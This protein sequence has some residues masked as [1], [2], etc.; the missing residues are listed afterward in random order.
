MSPSPPPYE[1]S[2]W[3][4]TVATSSK[5][6]NNRPV[7]VGRFAKVLFNWL[8]KIQPLR[9]IVPAM[10]SGGMDGRRLWQAGNGCEG[11]ASGAGRAPGSTGRIT[12]A[13]NGDGRQGCALLGDRRRR[14]LCRPCRHGD[15][16]RNVCRQDPACADKG[17]MD[18]R[19]HRQDHASARPSRKR[20]IRSSV[21]P[22]PPTARSWP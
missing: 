15:L 20:P 12:E 10:R 2:C 5:K 16:R 22:R 4:A 11:G 9:D 7:Y 13:S 14:R 1:T 8:P 18:R 6:N 3:V 21:S 17:G 19:Q